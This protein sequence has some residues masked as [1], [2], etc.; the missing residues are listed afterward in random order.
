MSKPTALGSHVYGGGFSCGVSRIFKVIGQLE[1]GPWG[2]ETFERNF[3][4][5][6]HPIGRE[7]WD[8]SKFKDVNLVFTNP[9]CSIWSTI[10]SRKGYDDP[11]FQFTRNCIDLGLELRPEVFVLESVCR[12]WSAGRLF[13]E[14]MAEKF[15]CLGY[16]VTILLT[17]GILHNGVQH[18]ERFHFIA[19]RGELELETP[20]VRSV[21]SV[22]DV[23][24]DLEETARFTDEEPVMAN[25]VVRRP[26][27]L[28]NDVLELLE[29]GEGYNRAVE[30]LEMLTGAKAGRWR[31][32]AKRLKW[33]EPCSTIADLSSL[34]HPHANRQL[35][36]REG[37]RLSGYPDSF[38]VHED[39]KF[40]T[41]NGRQEDLTQAVLPNMGEYL[42]KLALSS[43]GNGLALD[44]LRVV[45]WR[46]I[47]R[48]FRGSSEGHG[49][50]IK[51]ERREERRREALAA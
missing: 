21:A 19:H 25:H 1:E 7:N 22:G 39:P 46:K 13:Y 48:K 34:F 26:R 51:R 33:D 3:P 27:G 28:E 12:A 45:D 20:K 15:M 8:L 49:E 24:G 11:R 5:V 31:L 42:A 4:D 29:E 36:L 32:L 37:A 44:E 40:T 6:Y 41:H 9:P 17:N 50:D 38:I 10:G 2:A 47:G 14:Q 43:L 35:T 18:R 16:G 30:R 23:I